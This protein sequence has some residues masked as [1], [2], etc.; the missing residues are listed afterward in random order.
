MTLTVRQGRVDAGGT[1]LRLRALQVMGHGCAR[2]ARSG[3]VC[4]GAWLS[5]QRS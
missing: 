4:S 3:A 1:R 5:H 2:V